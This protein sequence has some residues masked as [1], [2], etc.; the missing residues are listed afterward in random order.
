MDDLG[1]IVL[2]NGSGSI[3]V[4]FSGEDTPRGIVSSMYGV[5]RQ[6]D[7]SKRDSYVGKA[8]HA[9]ALSRDA[10]DIVE[11]NQR[12]AIVDWDA[13]EK[14]W[15]YTLEHEMRM[16]PDTLNMPILY[17]SSTSTSSAAI[18][19]QQLQRTAQ[20]MFET[21]KATAFYTMQPS[22][23]SLFASGRTRGL[24]LE[25]GHG[26]SH[27]VPIFEGYA[28]PHATLHLDVGGM[29]ITKHLELLLTKH[30]HALKTFSQNLFA[31]MKESVCST[32]SLHGDKQQQQR[33]VDAKAFELPDGTVVSI[34]GDCR[35]KATD[36][37]FDPNLL[38]DDH[39]AK[40][41]KS[42]PD[43]ACQAVS[44]CD[45]ELQKDLRA[46]V[47]LAGGTTMIPGL[48]QRLHEELTKQLDEPL[49]IVPDYTTRERGY[50]THR[51]I[52]AWIGGSMFASLPTFQDMQ[53]TRQEWEENQESILERKCF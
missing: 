51:K 42:L 2:D 33:H 23:L 46:A 14:V 10:L 25:S 8:C 31:D 48:S 1:A 6:P 32:L 47:V 26:S 22:V 40:Q 39:P 45:K 9:A 27:A 29:D 5:N 13:M 24:V 34:H 49:R 12:G 4:G 52:A 16:N 7:G 15:D 17:T 37:L 11:P 44:M 3:K 35:T 41:A 38:P 50:N 18:N 28:L 20:L 53:I 30:G 43:L 21:Y 19:K 36:V